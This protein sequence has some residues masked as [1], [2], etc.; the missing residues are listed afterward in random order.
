MATKKRNE[1]QGGR[2]MQ[3]I[4]AT[5]FISKVHNDESAKVIMHFYRALNDQDRE[6]FLFFVSLV[7]DR[8]Y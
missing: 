8:Q 5:A 3:E 7:V 1:D 2:T 6:D 4:K